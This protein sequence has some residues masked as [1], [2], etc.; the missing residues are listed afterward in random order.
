MF[1]EEVFWKTLWIQSFHQLLPDQER[2]VGGG[3]CGEVWKL[4]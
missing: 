4:N 3:G 2:E 1:E